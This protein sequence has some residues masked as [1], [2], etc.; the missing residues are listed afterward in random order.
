M[1]RLALIILAIIFF[2]V[3]PVRAADSCASPKTSYDKTYCQAKLFLEGDNELNEVYK[4][5]SKEIKPEEKKKLVQAQRNWIKF[6]NGACESQGAINVDCN[7]KVN[8][9][10]AEILRDR[11]RECK[12]GHCRGDLMSKEDWTSPSGS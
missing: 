2:T 9:E 8:K 7:Y 4:D 12:T 11:L 6:R 3:P 1:H 5:L 10:R